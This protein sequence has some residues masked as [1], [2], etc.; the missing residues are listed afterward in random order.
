MKPPA[1]KPEP[2]KPKRERRFKLGKLKALVPRLSLTWVFTLIALSFGLFM[3]VQFHEAK[4]KLQPEAA[5]KKQISS[6]VGKVSKLAVIPQDETPTIITVLNASKVNNQ[7]FYQDAKDGD[8]VLVFNQKKRAILYRPS[9][10]Q[11]VNIAPVV[12]SP[13]ED[14]K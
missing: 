13:T 14:T 3:F 8:K 1:Q 2:P 10:N 5:S 12:V 6:L 4:A 9:T 11:I 7:T